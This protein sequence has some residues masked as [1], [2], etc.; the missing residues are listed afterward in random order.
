[1]MHV[2]ATVLVTTVVLGLA[3]PA[4]AAEGLIT[5]PSTHSADATLERFETALKARGLTIFARLD[6]QA[7]ASAAGLK[8]PRSTVVV[9]GNP[10]AGTPGFLAQPTLAIDLPMKALVHEDANG[11]VWLSYNSAKYVL[12]TIYARHGLP[13][14]PEAVTRQE[15]ALAAIADAAVN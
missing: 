9:F 6:H 3:V 14:N 1:M 13:A 10:R 8:M 11:K 15:E 4:Q 5:R 2:R 7:A 12:G